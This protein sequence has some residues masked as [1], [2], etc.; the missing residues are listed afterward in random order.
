MLSLCLFNLYAEYLMGN[1]RLDEKQAGIR[2]AARNINKFRYAD[3]II[4]IGLP[5]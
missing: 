5:M 3:D 2:I 1:T 4:L